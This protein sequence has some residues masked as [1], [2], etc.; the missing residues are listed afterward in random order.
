MGYRSSGAMWLSEAALAKL[1]SHTFSHNY[2]G[3]K[4]EVKLS[5]ELKEW[6]MEKTTLDTLHDGTE[7]TGGLWEFSYWK[8]YETYP[9]VD[10]WIA[11]FSEC[12]DEN[13]AF[14]FIRI[15]EDPDDTEV[16][17]GLYFQVVRDWN[18]DCDTYIME[19]WKH[20]VEEE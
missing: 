2:L 4:T 1:E 14:D 11:F 10:A 15:G 12:L 18:C 16:K 8:W 5:D 17:T 6:D 20:G 13:I 19:D 9:E 7:V 3:I